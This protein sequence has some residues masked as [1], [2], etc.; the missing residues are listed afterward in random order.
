MGN[1]IDQSSFA[2]FIF[3]LSG[4]SLAAQRQREVFFRPML[5]RSLA[6]VFISAVEHRGIF[7]WQLVDTIPDVALN[8]GYIYYYYVRN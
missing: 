7:R 5:P 6:V 2:D 8:A 4:L 1:S 3:S